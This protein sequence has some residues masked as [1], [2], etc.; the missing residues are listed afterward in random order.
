MPRPVGLVPR[1][2][3]P[4]IEADLAMCPAVYSVTALETAQAPTL[5]G[6]PG[7]SP[8]PGTAGH[9]LNCFPPCGAT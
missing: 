9:R 3:R 6:R 5:G 8:W 1:Y 4:I 7:P 2:P